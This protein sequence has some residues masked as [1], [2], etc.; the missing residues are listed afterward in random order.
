MAVECCYQEKEKAL[1][2]EDHPFCLLLG[3]PDFLHDDKC[4]P[5]LFPLCVIATV[6]LLS[7]CVFPLG[8]QCNRTFPVILSVS[9]SLHNGHPASS[10]VNLNWASI[11]PPWLS[12]IYNCKYNLANLAVIYLGKY[13]TVQSCQS[14]THIPYTIL[15]IWLSYTIAKQRE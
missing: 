1:C 11:L 5:P 9:D 6:A 15:P 13:H 12:Y 2:G 8:V 3:P 7:M 10:V 14:G 4:I